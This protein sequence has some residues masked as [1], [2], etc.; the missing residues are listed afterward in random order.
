MSEKEIKGLHEGAYGGVSG[1]AYEPYIPAKTVM[2]EISIV[3]IILGIFIAIVFGGAN[4]Y[5]GLKVGMTV[6]ASIPAAVISMGIIRGIM[7]RKWILENNMVQ[8]IGSAGESLAAGVIFTVPALFLWAREIEELSTPSLFTVFLMSLF[9]GLLGV[10]MMIPLRKFLIVQEH[11]KLLYPEGTACADILVAGEVGG[12]KAATVFIG[13][14]IGGLYKFIADGLKFFPSEIEW[15]I[16]GYKNAAVGGEIQ[17]ALLGVGFIIGPK[18][19]AYMLAGA[20]LGWLG[21][22]PIISIFGDSA[23]QVIPPAS[24]LISELGFWDIWNR[25]IRYIGAG[26][27]AFAGIISLIKSMPIIINSFRSALK[28]FK[29]DHTALKR[30][31]KDLPMNWVLILIAVIIV[32]IAFMPQI[33]TGIIGAILITIFAFFFVTVSARIVGVVGSSSNPISG[34]TIAT[35]LFTT[36]ILKAAGITGT[37]GMVAAI[38]V[39]GIVCIAAA[40]AG[41]TSQ[42]L[43]TGFLLGAS[44]DRQQIGEFIGVVASSLTI[45]FVL[46]LLDKA[47]GF[48]TKELAAPQATLMKLVIEGVMKANLPWELVFI[49]AASAAVIELLG[50]PS[51]PFAVGLYLPIHLSTPIMLGGL[52]RGILEKKERR[53]ELLKEKSEMGIL[54]ASGLIAGEGIVGILLAI[55]VTSGLNLNIGHEILG[56]IGGL[57]VFLA[58]AASLVYYAFF[59]VKHER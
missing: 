1:D 35:L 37:A 6:S 54:Y 45:G 9:G 38:T 36:I 58:L 31:D 29:V 59:S 10:V 19:A 13:L 47:Y 7:R 30:T 49:G 26:A 16:P 11:G 2:P 15:E 52:I 27:V 48:G 43:K 14:G 42:D 41:D 55:F 25:Y 34:M 56:P 46:V 22:I 8:T 33:P 40:I 50:I 3:S 21:F 4:A 53:R 28:G 32:L 17:P 44:P 23:S 57:I 39:G 24:K 5:L 18:I 20:V 51:L 12:S